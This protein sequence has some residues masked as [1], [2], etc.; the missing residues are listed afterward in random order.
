MALPEAAS[1]EWAEVGSEVTAADPAGGSEDRGGKAGDTALQ[2]SANPLGAGCGKSGG[3]KH[4]GGT[5][6]SPPHQ[7]LSWLH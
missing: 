1:L 4:A 2:A 5:S 3:E 6:W 7:P